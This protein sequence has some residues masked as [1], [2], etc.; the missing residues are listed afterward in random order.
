MPNVRFLGAETNLS[1]IPYAEGARFDTEKRCLPG[2]RQ[3]I[4]EEII[5]WVNRPNDIAEARVLFL[6]GVAGSGKSAIA[7]TV[8]LYFDQLGRLGSSFCFDR[9]DQAKRRPDNLFSTI[10]FDLADLDPQWKIS[11]SQV[12]QGKRAVRTT[13]SPSEQFVTFILQ[14]AKALTTTGPI[15]V[16]IDALDESGDRSSRKSILDVI[17][18]NASSLPVNFRI[19]ITARP[20]PDILDALENGRNHIFTK[21]MGSIDGISNDRDISMFIKTQLSDVPNFESEWPNRVA[22]TYFLNVQT[23]CSSIHGMSDHQRWRLW[24]ASNGPCVLS[25]T[26]GLD[27]L[28]LAILSGHQL[29]RFPHHVTLQVSYG[30]NCGGKRTPLCVSSR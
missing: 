21:N 25:S 27:G 10:A 18:K 30:Q 17:A 7:H 3:E 11:L 19:I 9:A 4:I 8:A 16:V 24:F 28:Y 20:E 1:E 14:P 15:I 5:E 13:R 23:G 6:S 12:V 29:A 26:R 2:T 22:V